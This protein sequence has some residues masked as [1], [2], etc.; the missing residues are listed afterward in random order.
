M[1]SSLWQLKAGP[2]WPESAVGPADGTRQLSADPTSLSGDYHRS[3][4][5]RHLQV[6][7]PAAHG[8]QF[9]ATPRGKRLWPAGCIRHGWRLPRSSQGPQV[10]RRVPRSLP[11]LSSLPGPAQACGGAALRRQLLPS[12]PARP[13]LRWE[14]QGLCADG[15]TLSGAFEMRHD[16]SKPA[17]CSC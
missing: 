3:S 5:L 10:P 4:S 15:V 11:R 1:P 7:S 17:Y 9:P 16:M 14:T 2:G 12:A 6:P 8:K 13:A